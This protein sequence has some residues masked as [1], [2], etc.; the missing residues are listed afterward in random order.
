MIRFSRTAVLFLLLFGIIHSVAFSQIEYQ[1]ADLWDKEIEAFQHADKAEM[2]KKGGVLFVGSSSI[3]MWK[4]VSSDFPDFYTI[5]RG[6]GGS[7]LEDV[8]HY[9][10]QIVIPYKP[11]LIVL[12]AGENDVMDSKT[13]ERILG[14]FKTFVTVIHRNLPK[15]RI[16]FVSLKPSSSRWKAADQFQE[17]NRLIEAETEKDKKLLF[18]NIWDKMLDADG[19]PKKEI[20]RDDKL[21]MN[22]SGYEIWRE[23]LLPAIKRGAK[24]NFR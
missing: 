21:H 14:D 19:M 11:K 2:P 23:I 3:R 16:I 12:Y 5:N 7:H 6:F 18:V 13:P 4:N 15:T 20:F 17:T 9:I 8:N 1:R 24:K 10:P 22:E